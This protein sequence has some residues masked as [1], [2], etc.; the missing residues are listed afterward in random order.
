M[1]KEF[2]NYEA[3]KIDC[4]MFN[5]TC[6]YSEIVLLRQAVSCGDVVDKKDIARFLYTIECR[7]NES[8]EEIGK[9]L[10]ADYFEMT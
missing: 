1:K 10:N 4:N 5:I 7:L 9:V 6:A 2:N 8:I 3:D